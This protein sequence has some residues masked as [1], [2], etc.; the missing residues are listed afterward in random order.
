[1][2]ML[3]TNNSRRFAGKRTLRKG[4]GKRFKTRCEVMEAVEA[5]LEYCDG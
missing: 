5:F 4:K 3:L 2:K 1:M